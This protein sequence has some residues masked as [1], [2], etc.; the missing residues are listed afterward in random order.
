MIVSLLAPTI[1][2]IATLGV[3]GFPEGNPGEGASSDYVVIGAGT[4][5]LTLA[6]RLA[7][8]NVTMVFSYRLGTNF[9]TENLN[10]ASMESNEDRQED[11]P[12]AGETT[13]TGGAAAADQKT[14]GSKPLEHNDPPLDLGATEG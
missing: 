7:E 12:G 9:E 8:A 4:S 14:G 6:A 2:S 10:A 1:L 13:G 3:H 11:D 5:G